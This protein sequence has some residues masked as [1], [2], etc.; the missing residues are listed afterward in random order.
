M[1]I[2]TS[3]TLSVDAVTLLGELQASWFVQDWDLAGRL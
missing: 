2:L 1:D 3:S